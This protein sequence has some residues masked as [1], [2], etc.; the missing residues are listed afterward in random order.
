MNT[1]LSVVPGRSVDTLLEE[2]LPKA[3]VGV[4]RA[5]VICK[6]EGYHLRVV[7]YL[8]TVPTSESPWAEEFLLSWEYRR[9]LWSGEELSAAIANLIAK[10]LKELVAQI[11]VGQTAIRQV[12][13][14]SSQ[15][16]NRI[17]GIE[18]D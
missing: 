7:L 3:K 8:P 6:G 5:Y 11:E 13:Q 15:A 16:S 10:I 2:L 18:I 4:Y 12:D 1:N 14:S 17:A 9:D